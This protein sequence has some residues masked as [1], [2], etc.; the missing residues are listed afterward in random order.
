MFQE[1]RLAR[2]EGRLKR[3]AIMRNAISTSIETT[4]AWNSKRQFHQRVVQDSLK[5]SADERKPEF[6]W[7]PPTADEWRL[8]TRIIALQLVRHICGYTQV[9]GFAQDDDRSVDRR[10]IYAHGD[11]LPRL[12]GR[13]VPRVH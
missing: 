3:E 12:C 10:I 2:G 1:C 6:P 8:A 13:D 11:L 9:G 4:V 7:E 5:T